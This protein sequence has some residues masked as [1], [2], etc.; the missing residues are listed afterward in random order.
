[1]RSPDIQSDDF[2]LIFVDGQLPA[3]G[4]TTC[5]VARKHRLNRPHRP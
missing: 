5:N 2:I 3:H 1:M 4:E